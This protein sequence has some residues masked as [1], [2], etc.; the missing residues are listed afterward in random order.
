MQVA[1]KNA[2]KIIT[3]IAASP[4]WQPTKQKATANVDTATP[5]IKYFIHRPCITK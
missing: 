2:L 3:F 4:I 5:S 1:A